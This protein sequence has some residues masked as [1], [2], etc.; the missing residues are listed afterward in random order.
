MAL[1][2]GIWHTG[3][4]R[5]ATILGRND[6]RMTAHPKEDKGG[7]LAKPKPSCEHRK[8]QGRRMKRRGRQKLGREPHERLRVQPQKLSVQ[9]GQR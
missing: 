7:P 1:G 3:A 6:P 4:G 2:K 5:W 9:Q 8:P